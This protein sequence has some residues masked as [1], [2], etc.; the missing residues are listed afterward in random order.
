MSGDSGMRH[1]S[2]VDPAFISLASSWIRE[3][4]TEF[5]R[6]VW[7]GYESFLADSPAVD[8]RDLERSIS[9]LLEPRIRRV[10]TGFEPFY[11]QHGAFERETMKPPPAQ[12]PEYDLAFVLRANET[13]MWPL[14]A[15]VIETSGRSADYTNDIKDQFLTCRYAPF[16]NSGAMLGYLLS[17]Q[18]DDFFNSVAQ[19]LGC[20]LTKLS[21]FPTKPNR[22]S[23]HVR[24]VP[25][26]KSYPHKFRC[27]HLILE[28]PKLRRTR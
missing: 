16:S 6:L 11:I 25:I 8:G 15:K 9:Q 24:K 12:P 21:E 20:S 7:E 10:M 17:G 22:L 1:I 28:F 19:V 2:T 27:Y 18:S 5:V 14:E 13:I 23:D 3:S 26:D 4:E